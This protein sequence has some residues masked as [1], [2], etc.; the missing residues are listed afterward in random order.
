MTEQYFDICYHCGQTPDEV[1]FFIHLKDELKKH[2]LSIMVFSLNPAHATAWE[3][4][5]MKDYVILP[6]YE[7]PVDISWAASFAKTLGI[8]N[9]RSLFQTE[10]IFYD[11]SESFCQHKMAQYVHAVEQL[12][13]A[14]KAKFYLTYGGDEFDHNAFRL[15]SRM[16]GGRS[17]Y[18]QPA[19]MAGR[20]ALFENEDRYWNIPTTPVPPL[21]DSEKQWLLDYMESYTAKKTILWGSP[22]ERD[23]KWQWDY[24]VR[25]LKRLNKSRSARVENPKAT[26]TRIAKVL[27]KRT[28]NRFLS[29]MYYESAEAFIQGRE[30][31][32]YFPLHYPKDSQLTLRGKPFLN[33]ASIVETV[34]RYVPYPYTL[35]V[36]EHPHA[37]GWYSVSD[38]KKMQELPNVKL[39]HPFTNSH[40][41]IP[42][43]K[44]IVAINSSVGYEGI[45]YRK[46][47]IAMGRSFYR[48]QGVTIDVHS[49]YE[50]EEAFKEMKNFNLSKDDV[51]GFLWR[52]KNLSCEF[53]D[54]FEKTENSSAYMAKALNTFISS[55]QST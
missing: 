5:G 37:R 33:Q 26:N 19:N 55:I 51:L 21:D 35:L 36:K 44:G 45:M 27:I 20:I 14:P 34:S 4:L 22:A 17:I 39:I 8:S 18:M 23:V 53:P 52:M 1:E 40:D 11:L 29:K 28:I 3:K 25:M 15:F 31:F 49:L 10:Q 54:L 6:K 47:V 43:A 24:P 32:V 50:L 42:Q 2:K 38:I 13:D 16:M 46:P 9:F 30:P 7:G 41:L 12:K 48:N